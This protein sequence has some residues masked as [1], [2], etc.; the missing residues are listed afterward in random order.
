MRNCDFEHIVSAHFGHPHQAPP[1]A[2]DQSLFAT[3]ATSH[4]IYSAPN[5]I[6]TIDTLLL[7]VY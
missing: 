4:R 2:L 7:I 3:I 6:C 5:Y 1:N